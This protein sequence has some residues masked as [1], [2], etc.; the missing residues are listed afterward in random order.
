MKRTLIFIPILTLLVSCS[1]VFIV[2]EM[3]K[4]HRL[5]TKKGNLKSIDVY[6]DA[7]EC[8]KEYET[9]FI[10]Q[11]FHFDF[12]LIAPRTKFF[13]NKISFKGAKKAKELKGDAVIIRDYYLV[14]IIKYID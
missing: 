13:K 6:W 3:E 11:P 7:G 4:E 9:I 8:K 1:K 12:P 2:E 5:N 10:Y 14:S